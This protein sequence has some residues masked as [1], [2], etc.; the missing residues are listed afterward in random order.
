MLAA[1]LAA[2]IDGESISNRLFD[3]GFVVGFKQNVLRF[4]PPLTI[5]NKEI[6]LLVDSLERNLSA[7]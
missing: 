4:M 2:D 5:T 3:E 1:E 7:L 6:D